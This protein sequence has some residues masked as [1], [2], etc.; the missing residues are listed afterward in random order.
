MT[1]CQM[2]SCGIMQE[3]PMPKNHALKPGWEGAVCQT[4]WRTGPTPHCCTEGNW[5]RGL[6][7][8]PAT[9]LQ[10]LAEC[11]VTKSKY[12]MELHMPELLCG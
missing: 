1:L 7:R 6:Y 2:W 4:Q 12:N 8:G 3:N 10:I 11:K 9:F 5:K